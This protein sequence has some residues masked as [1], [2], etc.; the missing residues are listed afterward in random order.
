MKRVDV[1]DPIAICDMG[2]MRGEE[3]DVD[4]AIEYW[5]KAAALGNIAHHNLSLMYRKG[6]CV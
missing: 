2:T 4:S 5:T 3:G 6:Q 1:N